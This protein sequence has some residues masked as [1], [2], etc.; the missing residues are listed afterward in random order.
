MARS[1]PAGSGAVNWEGLVTDGVHVVKDIFDDGHK[2]ELDDLMARSVPLGG[3]GAVNWEGLV[4][5]GVNVVKDIFDDGDKKSKRELLEL[6]ARA[7]PLGSGAVN[8]EGL[9]KDGVSVVHDIFE[10][11]KKTR[12]FVDVFARDS[13]GMHAPGRLS[14]YPSMHRPM[15]ASR[16]PR[17]HRPHY[18]HQGDF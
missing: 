6:I 14:Y 4:H 11:K 10:D 18:S 17:P 9:E 15:G 7:V 3:S 1:V 16:L 2:R 8:W 12:E 13:A 5:D